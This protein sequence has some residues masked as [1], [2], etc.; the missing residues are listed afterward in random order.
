MGL[1][2][3]QGDIGAGS[4]GFRDLSF[5]AALGVDLARVAS[6]TLEKANDSQ[7]WDF[8][9]KSSSKA[10]P[11]SRSSTHAKGKIVLTP[12]PD[13]RTYERLIACSIKELES[14]PNTEKL[15]CNRAYGLFSQVVHYAEFLQGISHITMGGT[16]ARADIDLSADAKFGL[17]ES[18]VM[19]YCD[20]VAI[21]TFIQVVGLL[22]N[23][24]DL[25]TSEDVYVAT[26]VDN[27]SMSSACDFNRHRSWTV[28][29]KYTTTGEGQAAGDIFV[30]TR[31]GT[32]AMIITGA[33]FTKLLISKLERFLDSANAK[34]SQA[35]AVANKILP[36]VAEPKSSETTS[37]ATSVGSATPSGINNSSSRATSVDSTDRLAT[38][39]GDSDDAEMS[40]RN[41]IATYTGISPAE[42]AHDANVGDLGVDSLAA[43]ELAEEL[44]AQFGK[45]VE[46]EDLLAQTFGAL[47][48]LLVPFASAKKAKV[49]T[50]K[51]T[52]PPT[53]VPTQTPSPSSPPSNVNAGPQDS[54]GRQTALKLLS[55]TS[56]AP[57][58]SIEGKA[59]LQ[60][61]GIDSLSAVELKGDL[62]DAFDIEIEDDRFTLESTVQEV[63][64]FLG[65]G[66]ATQGT[67]SSPAAASKPTNVAK[68]M[69]ASNDNG[70]AAM[71]ELGSP[72]EAIVQCEAAFDRAASQRG[73]LNYWSEVA[74]KQDELLLAYICEA[75]Q[76]L[77]S[78]IGRIAQGQQIPPISHLPKHKKVM[79]RL[80]DILEKHRLVNRQGSNLIRGNGNVPY[81]AARELHEQ[82]IARFPVYAGEA[83]LMALTGPK[84]GD[85]LA[86]KADAVALM[87][88]GAAAQKVM[89]DYYC[90]SPMLSTLTEQ[91]VTFIRTIVASSSTTSK[92]TPI[93]VLEVGAGFGGTTT[94][95]AEVLEESGLP[96]SYKFTDISPSL[97]KNA[98]SKFAKYPWMEFQALN[99]ETDM[100]A[101]LQDTYD[102]VL[103]TNCV[104]ATT[105]KTKTITRLKS[106][107]NSQGFIVLSE[108]TQLVDWY[109]IVFGLLDGWWLANDGSTYPLQPPES[110][111]RSF[112]TA[113]FSSNRISYTQGPSPE[114]NTQR[115]LI[116]SNNQKVT[117][118][119][120]R[121]EI[122]PSVQTVVYKEV[123]GTQVEA[124]IYMPTQASTKAMPIGT[125]S[126]F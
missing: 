16:E 26:G 113:G 107:L 63:L 83:R 9:I 95:L 82:F 21:D 100:P 73:F 42:I 62:E 123:D 49:P 20:T 116:A 86:G 31:D 17:E 96:V 11:K 78:D 94:R 54:K 109:D 84:L 92:A 13:F 118:P 98:K 46:A 88:R 14:K 56:G 57:I 34:P 60:E 120:R 32:L 89:E 101:S 67:S 77:G 39:E 12:E 97:V 36:Q 93:R 103:G 111:I 119:L 85:C 124:D 28:Y 115:L 61:L 99:L 72:M 2:L 40:L 70:K 76:A 4:L 24:S 18:T 68:D 33:Q 102:I 43:V 59:T 6:L 44:Q 52:G 71:I 3:L 90:A 125:L 30:M 91:L 53:A 74:P 8:M 105:N 81:T 47:A 19:Q 15:M 37:S 58:P 126:S 25:V 114:S 110:W 65:V 48:G 75:F 66:S 10:D 27:V 64:D 7:S 22:I 23:S 108:V 87:F 121:E 79:N 122:G 5:Q 38:E 29:T 1:Q 104:H 55:E 106:L 50:Q 51:K 112:E 80:V 45:E 35:T 69:S 117:A 41:I